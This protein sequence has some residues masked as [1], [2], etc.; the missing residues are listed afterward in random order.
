M[1]G[2]NSNIHFYKKKDDTLYKIYQTHQEHLKDMINYGYRKRFQME[3]AEKISKMLE[4]FFLK[5][6]YGRQL[7]A[8]CNGCYNNII[9]HNIVYE[10]LLI[11][12]K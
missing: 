8:I 3:H 11:F 9:S 10:R 4:K 5:E 7:G 2:W 12:I 6:A 1:S